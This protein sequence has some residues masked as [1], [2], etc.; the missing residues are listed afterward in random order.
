M[1]D[2][3]KSAPQCQICKAPDM[4][5][6]ECQAALGR[7][8]RLLESVAKRISLEKSREKPAKTDAQT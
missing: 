7:Y 2:K 3:K 5:C 1:T 4:S 6:L 8:V